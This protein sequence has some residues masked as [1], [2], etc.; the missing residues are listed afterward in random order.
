M[1]HKAIAFLAALALLLPASAPAF[2]ESGIGTPTGMLT[3]SYVRARLSAITVE[4]QALVQEATQAGLLG[5]QDVLGGDFAGGIQPQQLWSGNGSTG[6]ISPVSGLPN[7][8][9]PGVALL[10]DIIQCSG[11]WSTVSTSTTYT[12]TTFCAATCVYVPPGAPSGITL[13]LPAATSSYPSCGFPNP[14]TISTQWIT[15]DSTNTVAVSGG[16]GVN[17][18]MG[19]NGSTTIAASSTMVNQGQWISS[20]SIDIFANQYK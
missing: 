3:I 14:G 20:S 1:K 9:V 12:G 15:N 5:N 17:F 13:A 7:I 2:A 18:H 16:T 10:N 11:G 8:S 19:Y 6:F 4:L